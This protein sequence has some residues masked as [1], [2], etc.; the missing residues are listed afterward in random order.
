MK[1]RITSVVLALLLCMSLCI[2]AFAV[3]TTPEVRGDVQVES[4]TMPSVQPQ[5]VTTLRTLNVDFVSGYT[6][7]VTPTKGTNLK[8]VGRALES[9]VTL[10]V[11][12]NGGWWPSKTVTLNKSDDAKSYDLI[13]NCNGEPYELIFSAGGS[14]TIIGYVCQTEYT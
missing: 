1:K 7:K 3:D 8:F 12:K 2:P 11:Y 10:E 9:N 5:T 13:T 4:A 6:V 14:A